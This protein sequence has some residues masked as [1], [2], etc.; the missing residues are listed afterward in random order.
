M[1]QP[2]PEDGEEIP[3]FLPDN[4]EIEVLVLWNMQHISRK[5]WFVIERILKGDK[6]AAYW[7]EHN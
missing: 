1:P 7:G 3:S 2:P 6:G 4:I 5:S